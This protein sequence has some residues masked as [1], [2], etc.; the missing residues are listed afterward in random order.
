MVKT[1]ISKISIDF[2][3]TSCRLGWSLPNAVLVTCPSAC[4]PPLIFPQSRPHG[5][6]P[7]HDDERRV[8]LLV[9]CG[10]ALVVGV[11][12]GC[13]AVALRALIGF[14]HNVFY[15]GTIQHLVRCEHQRRGKPVWQ[16][17]LSFAGSRRPRRRLSGAALRPGGQGPRRSRGDGCGILQARQYPRARLRSS[18]RWPR[19]CR[20]APGRRSA[21]R[22][23][24]SDRRGAGVGLLA[25]DQALDLAEDH[26]AFGRC[27]RRNRRDVQHAAWRSAVRPGNSV[28]RGLEPHL[29]TGRRRD[30]RRH[31]HRQD[32]DR[33][34]SGLCRSRI[35]ISCPGARSAG[36][37][38]RFCL[39]RHPV[40]RRLLGLYSPA[41]GDGGW[42][43][44]N[45]GKC[46]YAEYHRHGGRS[47]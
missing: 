42:V 30:R 18:N 23:D 3:G 10:L 37:R 29:S 32:I 5:H 28:A 47:A 45:A 19:R 27:R 39:A 6:P 20:L 13:G 8:N 44:Q 35:Q 16:L 38:D 33:T 46:L 15:N 31:A 2:G 25:G 4:F 17:G 41:R 14:F 43:S 34:R 24:H 22:A 40:R 7:V 11:M 9:L 36:G 26:T 1:K 12:T 21:A